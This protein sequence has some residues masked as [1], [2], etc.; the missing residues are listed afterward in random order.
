MIFSNKIN[1]KITSI[2][3]ALGVC[4]LVA[5]VHVSS[6]EASDPTMR[7]TGYAW[8]SNIGWLSFNDGSVTVGSNGDLTG[9]AW[10]SNIGWVKF[11]GLS[12][13]PDASRG[14]NANINGNS[15]TG[16]ARAVSVMKPLI[17]KSI[18][19]RGGWDGWISLSSGGGSPSYGVTLNPS[20]YKFSGF[21]WG[22]DVVGWLDWSMVKE[23]DNRSLC[24]TSDGI[25]YDGQTKDVT[26]KIRSGANSGKCTTQTFKCS[27]QTLLPQGNPSAPFSC[28]PA[29]DCEDRDGIALKN[30][31]SHKFFKDRV[32]TSG[33]CQ[34]DTLTCTDGVLTGSDGKPDETYLYASCVVIPGYKEV[35]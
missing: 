25:I 15:L 9:Y 23:D 24:A 11:G 27:S 31:E 22:S 32:L 5:L 33:T 12:G 35:Q 18:D 8:S 30:G 34:S 21:A 6:A 16:W 28:Q 4:A 2:A 19:N 1:K 26:T 13:F 17:I 3:I 7:L 14:T 20:N 29:G 10:S